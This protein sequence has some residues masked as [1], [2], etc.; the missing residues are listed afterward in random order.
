MVWTNQTFAM[1]TKNIY[2]SNLMLFFLVCIST[3]NDQF[4]FEITIDIP[5]IHYVVLL[6][7]RRLRT[8]RSL[9]WILK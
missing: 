5:A 4:V 1:Q 9:V 3:Q 7:K 8:F 6:Y 2:F